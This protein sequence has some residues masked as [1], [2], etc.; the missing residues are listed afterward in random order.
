MP[1]GWTR[2]QRGS[3]SRV[4]RT[5]ATR[6]EARTGALQ[7]VSI[8]PGRLR[9]EV[10]QAS[11]DGN[12]G[13][14]AWVAATL[15]EVSSQVHWS[16]NLLLAVA[17]AIVAAAFLLDPT[18][19]DSD[20]TRAQLTILR[21]GLV[22]LAFAVVV[23]WSLR[24]SLSEDLRAAGSRWRSAPSDLSLRSLV[25]Q[26]PPRVSEIAWVVAGAWALSVAVGLSLAA[27][28]LHDLTFENGP[29]ETLTVVAYLVGFG[30]AIAG[31]RTDSGAV[32][33]PGLRRWVLLLAAL[34]C[35]L[36]AG[37]ETDW[38]QVYLDYA[39]PEAFSQANIQND[40]SLHNLAPP[41]VVPGT[42]W[43]NWTLRAGA[44]A[45]GGVVPLLLLV[46]PWFRRWMW[47]WEIPIPPFVCQALLF[48]SAFVPEAAEMYERNNVGSEIREVTIAVAVGLWMATAWYAGRQGPGQ[49]A[50]PE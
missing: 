14:P 50:Q 20:L 6:I 25:P 16:W 19:G 22:F 49:S 34:G 7:R 17:V 28:W 48:L 35:F 37:E 29:L 47:A 45:L 30:F 46:S 27:A 5:D 12:G 33:K 32:R 8:K 44:F 1:R 23:V 15:R 11:A 38:G 10:A 4:Y 41:G 24:R 31:I 42:R 18:I 26:P 40:L 36:I 3:G 13:F 43:A 39:T 2:S 21:G 9:A